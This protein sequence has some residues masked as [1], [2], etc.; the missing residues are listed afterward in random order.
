MSLTQQVAAK[1]SR[2]HESYGPGWAENYWR[3]RGEPSREAVVQGLKRLSPWTSLVELGCNAGP[4]LAAIRGAFPEASLGG[5]DVNPQ[6]I[7]AAHQNV[8]DARCEVRS[9]WDWLPAQ[10]AASIDVIV[11][12]YT[13]AYVSPED[14]QAILAQM[15]RATRVG[16]VIAE[17][18]GPECMV[19][20]YPEWQHPYPEL[21][22]DLGVQRAEAAPVEPP[23][24]HLNAVTTAWIFPA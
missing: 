17:P 21:L 8:P 14:I 5:I 13:L 10:P 11:T 22:K 24:G 2:Q 15:A 4:Q 19:Y 9:L 18:T 6:A 20:A 7:S 23:N 16:L 1:W 12:H 3:T